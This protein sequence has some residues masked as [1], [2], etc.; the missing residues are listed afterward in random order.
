MSFDQGKIKEKKQIILVKKKIEKKEGKKK[1]VTR[2]SNNVVHI[3]LL[4]EQT[5]FQQQQNL[6]DKETKS[7]TSN[8]KNYSNITTTTEKTS[9]PYENF[10]E[11]IKRKKNEVLEEEKN[12]A[13]FTFKNLIDKNNDKSIKQ[14]YSKIPKIILTR[15]NQIISK[16]SLSRS[17]V[18]KNKD[19]KKENDKDEIELNNNDDFY[20][21]NR[22]LNLISQVISNKEASEISIDVDENASN[23][24]IKEGQSEKEV[25]NINKQK[26]KLQSLLG[27]NLFQSIYTFVDVKTDPRLYSL[28]VEEIKELLKT[29]MTKLEY[30]EKTIELS[31]S[32][33]PNI[34]SILS[35][36]RGNKFLKQSL[37]ISIFK[38]DIII[39]NYNITYFN[40]IYFY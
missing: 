21:A 36:E 1:N 26:E 15:D 7:E 25:D 29:Q 14:S 4:N 2:S 35:I 13:I 34:L 6:S 32:I 23:T 28:S 11:F 17:I 9:A 8:S 27:Y 22:Y 39:V 20:N 5:K 19:N 38:Y 40:S 18:I 10:K 33:I 31:V 24:I 30:S 37:K 12:N 16:K 3:N